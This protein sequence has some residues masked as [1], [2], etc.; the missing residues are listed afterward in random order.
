M[1]PTDPR[2]LGASAGHAPG[3]GHHDPAELHNEGV[4]H[5]HSDVDVRR[6]LT[7]A[8]GLAIVIGAAVVLMSGMFWFLERQA[9]AKDPPLSP[10]AIP[11]AQMPRT[12]T[13]SPFFGTATGAPQLLT[14]EPTV[15]LKQRSSEA[16]RLQAYGWVDEKAGVARMPIEEAKKLILRRGLPAREGAPPTTFGT[17]T[18]ARGESSGGRAIP[19]GR[20]KPEPPAAAPAPAPKPPG[21]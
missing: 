10:L 8:V 21:H 9:Q 18:Q 20:E 12:T 16:E 2:P 7:A 13:A 11:A 6:I 4:A 19:T 1:T 17:W 5:E 14:N 3:H 15:L